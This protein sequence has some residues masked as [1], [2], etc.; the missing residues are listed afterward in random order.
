MNDNATPI[1]TLL[2]KA[3]DYSKTS[4]EYFKLSAI[5]KSADMASSLVSRLAIFTIVALSLVI[6]N[7]GLSLWIGKQLGESFYGFFIMGGFYAILAIPVHI[8]RNQWIKSPISN[9][10]IKRLL[11][12][13][14]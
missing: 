9:S 3:E 5:D 14:Q 13:K 7:I 1:E 4:I 10:L 11:K 2:K 8:F 6:L 12:Q